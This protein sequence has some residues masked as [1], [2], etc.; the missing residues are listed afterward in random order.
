[1]ENFKHNETLQWLE[2]ALMNQRFLIENGE[3][4][5]FPCSNEQEKE[6]SLKAIDG[7]FQIMM[8]YYNC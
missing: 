2:T 4:R 6:I 1:M 3:S 7:F 8:E 5:K